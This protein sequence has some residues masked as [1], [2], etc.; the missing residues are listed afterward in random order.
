MNAARPSTVWIAALAAGVA[1]VALLHEIL[2]P[3]VAGI[4]LAYLLNPVVNRIARLGVNRAV[5]ALGIVG[6][7]IIGVGVL[8]VLATPIIGTEVATLIEKFPGYIGQL[9][10]LANDPG[11]PWLRKIIGE[12]L[13]EAQQSAGKLT[14][15]AADWITSFLRSLWSNSGA[16]ISIFSLLVVTPIVTVYLL[17]D[18]KRLIAAID[19]SIPA[20]QR[21]TVLALAGEIDDTIAGFVHGQGT[22]CLIL[23][24]YYALALRLIGLN[25]GILIGLAAGLMSFI[26]YLGTFTGLV[27][28]L[29][30]AVLQFWPSWTLIPVVLGIFVAGEAIADYV[31]APYLVASRIHLN[32]VWVMFAI[33]AFGYL[34]GF[35]GLL[36]AVPLAAAIGVVVRWFAT[37][38]YL[39]SPLDATNQHAPAPALKEPSP[40]RKHWLR[41]ILRKGPEF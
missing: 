33:A 39:V 4:A 18:W 10:A 1:V 40:S 31:L 28:S 22:I 17:N 25:Y 21:G 8:I 7:F 12:G 29:C 26:P 2:L 6:L 41:A 11:R 32:P 3:F 36:I 20:A 9:Q 19:R 16:L 5:A 13:S 37:R 35:V 14:S 15:M 30:V 23:A 38:Q 34:F 27:L 24:F